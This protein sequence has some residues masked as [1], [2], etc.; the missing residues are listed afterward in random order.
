MIGAV[1][2]L[3]ERHLLRYDAEALPQL[4]SELR[5]YTTPDDY[6]TTDCVMSLAFAVY[7]AEHALQESRV[8]SRPARGRRRRRRWPD[9][10]QAGKAKDGMQLDPVRPQGPSFVGN[11]LGR[12]MGGAGLE[13]P[14]K[15][16]T[17]S[18]RWGDRWGNHPR[19]P[20]T[21]R[22]GA[23]V[24]RSAFRELPPSPP[25]GQ[26][27]PAR[28]HSALIRSGSWGRAAGWRACVSRLRGREASGG[29]AP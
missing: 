26:V 19:T 16:R 12:A 10:R 2:F 17:F 21:R 27:A 9:L 5:G 29:T 15:T 28:E 8:A 14:C 20:V 13:A 1:Q 7:G 24:R 3:I 25:E 4:D 22:G 11:R 18:C 6:I 23:P